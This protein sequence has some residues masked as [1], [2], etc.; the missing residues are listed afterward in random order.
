MGVGGKLFGYFV[1]KYNPTEVKS[2]ADRRWTLDKDKNLY[3]NLGFK[4]DEILKPDYRYYNYKVDKVKRFHKFGFRK[5]ILSKKY[6][7]P[8]EMTESEMTKAIGF[9]KIWDCGLF[10]YVW[11]NGG[12]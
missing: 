2:F 4:L 6:G 11:K 1:R 8:M 7:F 10:R 9:D 3:T 12:H 5:E